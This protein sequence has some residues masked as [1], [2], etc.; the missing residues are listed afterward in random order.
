MA[1]SNTHFIK[2][3]F[4]ESGD[5]TE[6]PQ[7]IQS[8]GS[9]SYE[10]GFPEDYSIEPGVGS[11]GKRIDRGNFNSIQNTV[12]AAVKSQQETSVATWISPDDNNGVA[13]IYVKGTPVKHKGTVFYAL[14]DNGAEPIEGAQ[15]SIYP[16]QPDATSSVKGISTIS[17]SVSS[18]S[19]KQGAS[20]K[21]VKRVND[22]AVSAKDIAEGS[23]QKSNN[24][25]DVNSNA[26]RE[27]LGIFNGS[28]TAGGV[29]NI[30]SSAPSGF[31]VAK[32]SAGTYT[33][34]Y[35]SGNEA[36]YSVT[37]GADEG[38]SCGL[39]FKRS[40]SFQVKTVR[41]RNGATEDSLF[42]FTL[43]NNQ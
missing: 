39:S 40:G 21:A 14:A 22:V 23:V 18:S 26:S 20:S 13:M 6:V 37:F 16:A 10:G 9:V 34:T 43:I 1:K 15:W 24:L 28:V 42:N 32:V 36:D 30:P 8:D 35:N 17:D 31:T 5:L 29:W 4:A 11:D 3:P 25:S 19:S 12:E 33:I 38:F 41:V 27:N 7:Q 2:T